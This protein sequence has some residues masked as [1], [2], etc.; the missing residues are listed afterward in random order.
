M[1]SP[2]SV[3]PQ[4]SEPKVMLLGLRSHVHLGSSERQSWHVR[5]SN[6]PLNILYIWPTKKN[7]FISQKYIVNAHKSIRKGGRISRLRAP[8]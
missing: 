7:R 3:V 2:P 8:Q 5:T 1:L 4:V 6:M